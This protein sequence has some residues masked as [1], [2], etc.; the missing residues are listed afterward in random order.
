[1]IVSDSFDRLARLL[2]VLVDPKVGVIAYL[3]EQPREHGTPDFIHY[4]ARACDASAIT[5]VKNFRSTGGAA[6]SRDAAMAKA[7]GEAVERYCGSI[8]DIRVLPLS[9]FAD[10]QFECMHPSEFSLYS[11]TQYRQNDF[12]FGP[13]TESTPVRWCPSLDLISKREVSV[14]AAM[15]YV[16]YFFVP[17]IGERPIVQP[18]S[19]GLACHQTYAKAV[20]SAVCEVIERDAFSIVWLARVSPPRIR[21]ETLD[22]ANKDRLR[23][24][25]R[26][27]CEV[28]L[29][30]LTLDIRVPTVLAVQRNKRDGCPPIAFA[31]ATGGSPKESVQKSLEELAHTYRY[32]RHILINCRRLNRAEFFRNILNQE[33]H[34]NLWA[35]REML[36]AA[37]FL[38]SSD[39][40]VNADE[41]PDHS[42]RHVEDEMW[43]IVNAVRRAGYRTLISDVTTHDVRRIGLFV[44]RAIVPGLHSLFWNHSFRSLGGSRLYAA[45]QRCGF[46]GINTEDE[47]NPIPHPYP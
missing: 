5:G 38:F 29:L 35:D 34:L 7:L 18:M 16:P 42:G 33:D 21:Q 1:M 20:T 10:A 40:R 37:D 26:S 17:D 31:A 8:Y 28:I 41:L 39:S 12:L 47:A 19:T 13:F 30:D 11:K 2:E 44:V 15:V 27:G 32:M 25:E 24:F 45:P 23:R 6:T 43:S 36:G 3:M 9:T 46:S 4:A 22:P 14:P